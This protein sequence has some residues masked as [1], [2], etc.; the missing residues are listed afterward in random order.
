MASGGVVEVGKLA[1]RGGDLIGF[2]DRKEEHGGKH[3]TKQGKGRRDAMGQTI[4]R[5]DLKAFAGEDVIVEDDVV[6]YKVGRK[7]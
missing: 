5:A 1:E 4:V 3:W 6:G 2:S 7:G